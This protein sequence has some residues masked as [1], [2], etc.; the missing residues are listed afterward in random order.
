MALPLDFHHEIF[1]VCLCHCRA[2]VKKLIFLP[3]FKSFSHI[4]PYPSHHHYIAPV[5]PFPNFQNYST[6]SM[7]FYDQIF[8]KILE[9]S[10]SDSYTLKKRRE[11]EREKGSAA[12]LEHLQNTKNSSNNQLSIIKSLFPPSSSPLFKS[13]FFLF[14][15]LAFN[16]SPLHYFFFLYFYSAANVV[17]HCVANLT[18]FE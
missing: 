8:L 10:H 12:K 3:S 9:N 6:K 5:R 18:S 16:S 2:F 7:I 17:T 4:S 11:R 13:L 1:L 14:S 15:L